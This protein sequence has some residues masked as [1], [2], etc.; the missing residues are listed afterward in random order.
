MHQAFKPITSLLN[1]R[2]VHYGLI[3][4]GVGLALLFIGNTVYRNWSDFETFSWQLNPAPLVGAGAALVA[5]FG[6]NVATWHLISSTFGSRVGLWKDVEIYS[7]ST[8]IRRLPGV[9]WQLAGRT[10]LYH[11]AQTSLAVPLWGTV[12]ELFVQFSSGMLLTA[13][14]LLLSPGL[15]AEFPGGMWALLLLIPIGWFALR[16]RDVVSLVKRL[17]P[18]ATGEPRLTRRRVSAW[19]GLYT[20]SWVL[21][22]AILY[23]LICALGPQSWTLLPVCVGLVATSGVLALLAAPIPG[24]LGIREISLILLLQPYVPSPVAVS[25][26]IMLRLCLLLGEALIALLIFLAVRGWAWLAPARP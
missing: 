1:N 8:V 17:V 9:V 18:K 20:L 2:W 22:G 24:G 26:A 23:A 5:A 10:Y 11:Q 14:M 15:R 25:A 6:L 4:T 19:I 16:P 3:L 13:L 12:W 21:G 7:V